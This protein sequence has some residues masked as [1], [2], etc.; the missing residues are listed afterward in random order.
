[1][2]R[3]NLKDRTA[4][5]KA[6]SLRFQVKDDPISSFETHFYLLPEYGKGAYKV[7]WYIETKTI[8]HFNV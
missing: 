4:F 7:S 5:R 8:G 2:L 6:N 3:G 1:M